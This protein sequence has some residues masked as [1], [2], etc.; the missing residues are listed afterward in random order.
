MDDTV[1]AKRPRKPR[2][3]RTF[4]IIPQIVGQNEGVSDLNVSR[5]LR[6]GSLQ[7]QNAQREQKRKQPDAVGNKECVIERKGEVSEG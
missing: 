4:I 6:A 2:L 1:D 3:Q 5:E 7:N